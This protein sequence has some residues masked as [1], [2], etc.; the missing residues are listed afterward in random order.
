MGCQGVEG[1]LRGEASV[2]RRRQE[3]DLVVAVIAH[4][5]LREFRQGLAQVRRRDWSADRRRGQF[6]APSEGALIHVADAGDTQLRQ[7]SAKIGLAQH[8][9][10]G[11]WDAVLAEDAPGTRIGQ[12]GAA[13]QGDVLYQCTRCRDAEPR[14]LFSG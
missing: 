5:R 10:L 7:G 1:G 8:L 13:D 12:Q 2:S 4:Q 11:E 6:D 14:E 9:S 3:G